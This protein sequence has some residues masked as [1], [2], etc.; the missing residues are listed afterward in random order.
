MKKILVTLSL[1]V[2]LSTAFASDILPGPGVEENFK[3]QFSG[4]SKVEWTFDGSYYKAT[5]ILGGHRAIAYYDAQEEFIGCMRNIFFDQLPLSVM[6]AVDKRFSDADVLDVVEL[7]SNEGTK[8][9]II[10]EIKEKKFTVNV[11]P[12]GDIYQVDKLGK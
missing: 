10:L 6:T 8:Y 5:F 2:T 12:A 7:T 3:K 9:K 11:G 1:V 4:A